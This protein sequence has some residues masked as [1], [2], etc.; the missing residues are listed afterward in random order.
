VD[1]TVGQRLLVSLG[2]LLA[3]CGTR[4]IVFP[5]PAGEVNVPSTV[6]NEVKARWPG[7]SIAGGPA[8]PGS[9][10]PAMP[11]ALHAD[12][13]GDLAP[14][15]VL[16]VEGGGTAHLVAGINRLDAAPLVIDITG[17]AGLPT[18]TLTIEPRGTRYMREGSGLDLYFGAETV[19]LTSC[20]GARTAYTWTGSGFESTRLAAP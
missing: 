20:D 3:G 4:P 1:V 5:G 18:S 13:N 7:A 9:T 11:A 12:L 8:C 2:L 19:V 16:R 17:N 6:L 10:G 14:D 15:L